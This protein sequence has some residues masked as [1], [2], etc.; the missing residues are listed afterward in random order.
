MNKE[1]FKRIYHT[2]RLFLILSSAKRADYL[3]KHHIFHS[4]GEGC[5][6]M[7]RKVPLSARLISIGNNVH[8]ASKVCLVAHDA[9]HL[10]L[11]AIKR[12]TD[13]PIFKEKIGCIQIG[14][15][16]FVGSNTTILYDVKIGSNVIIGACSL[17]NKDIPDNSVVVGVPAKVIGTFDDFVSKRIVNIKY[18][19]ELTPTGHNITHKLESWMWCE[20]ENKRK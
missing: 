10:C 19:N 17:V 6:I 20:F 4:I 3:R 12:T 1:T 5:T 8:L 7:E 9:I 13:G 18:P 2:F 16:V 11:N 15:N 14:D